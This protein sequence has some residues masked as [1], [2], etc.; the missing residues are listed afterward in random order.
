MYQE[1]KLY[2]LFYAKRKDHLLLITIFGI[3]PNKTKE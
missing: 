3:E 1:T 2:I